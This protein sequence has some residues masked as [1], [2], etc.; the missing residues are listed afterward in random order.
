MA[1]A[2]FY[3]G[4]SVKAVEWYLHDCDLPRLRWARLRVFDDGTAD[5]CW[6][7][8]GK[9][10]GFDSREFA[11]SFLTEDE[12]IRFGNWDAADEASYGV[13]MADAQVPLWEDRPG[14]EFDYL[15][16]H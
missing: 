11:N 2:D 12:Y 8:D 15:G 5:A 14:Q 4:K 1:E 16:T 7:R 3:R 6:E 13:R 9:R 10:Y